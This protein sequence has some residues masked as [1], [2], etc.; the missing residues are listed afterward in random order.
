MFNGENPN[1]NNLPRMRIIEKYLI[2]FL[3][4]GDMGEE[5]PTTIRRF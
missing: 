5:A 2:S 1:I 4:V 3:P